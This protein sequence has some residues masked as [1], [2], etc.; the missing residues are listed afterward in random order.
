MNSSEEKDL[1][2]LN[3]IPFENDAASANSAAGIWRT[4][5]PNE[6]FDR[7]AGLT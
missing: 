6:I 3:L 5:L 1:P 7:I 2:D 4:G